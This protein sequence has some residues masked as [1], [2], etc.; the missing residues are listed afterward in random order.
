MSRISLVAILGGV[1]FTAM[2]FSQAGEM[3]PGPQPDMAPRMHA[4]CHP[5]QH[6]AEQEKLHDLLELTPVQE[7]AWHSFVRTMKPPLRMAADGLTAPERAKQR[8]QEAQ[9]HAEAV[10]IL[11]KVLTPTQRKTFDEFRPMAHGGERLREC[12]MG[13]KHERPGPEGFATEGFN[14]HDAHPH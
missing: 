2:G 4:P 7:H 11:Y 6:M 1:L 12:D 3:Q 5:F 14:A 9:Q 8:A 10:A 13:L